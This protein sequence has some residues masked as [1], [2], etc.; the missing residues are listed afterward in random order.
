MNPSA[1][2]WSGCAICICRLPATRCS[3][4]STW[5]FIAGK[6]CRSSVRPA[7]KSTILRCITGLLQPQRGSIRVGN[8]DV[9]TLQQEAQRIRLRKRVGFVFQQYNLFPHLSVLQNLVVAP[10]K[11]LGHNRSD[12]EK[13]HARYSP[14]Y[15]WNTRPMPIRDNCPAVSNNAWRLPVPWRCARN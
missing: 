6:R 2:R 4:A 14:K 1:N 5:T 8:T 12:A 10:R 13:A 11:V 7:R 15:A 3:K 9:H